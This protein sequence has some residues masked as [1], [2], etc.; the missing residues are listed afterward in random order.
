MHLYIIHAVCFWLC[1][2]WGVLKHWIICTNLIIAWN[3]SCQVMPISYTRIQSNCVYN[4]KSILYL[5]M[6]WR[7]MPTGL[8]QVYYQAWDSSFIKNPEV[9]NFPEFQIF[10]LLYFTEMTKSQSQLSVELWILTIGPVI[11]VRFS[12]FKVLQRAGTEIY[13]FLVKY[14]SFKIRN[15]KKNPTVSGC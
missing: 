13:S 8:L 6:P 11:L 9:V 1:K 12:K 2:L 7:Q 15:S 10:T 5:L 3:S 14:K 4:V